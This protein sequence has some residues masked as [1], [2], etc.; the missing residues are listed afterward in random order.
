MVADT[1]HYNPLKL[2]K[3]SVSNNK[4]AQGGI[5]NCLENLLTGIALVDLHHHRNLFLRRSVGDVDG[6]SIRRH[7]ILL[8]DGGIRKLLHRNQR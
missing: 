2:A 1:A 8:H 5:V 7:S 3:A 4:E 6:F